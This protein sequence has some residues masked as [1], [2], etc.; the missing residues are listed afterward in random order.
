MTLPSPS[1]NPPRAARRYLR[2]PVPVHFPVSEE[3]PET[4]RHFK[5]RAL[6]A[7]SIEHALGDGALVCSDQF[8]YWDATDP[9]RCLA[10]DVAFRVG[11]KRDVPDT[12]KTWERGAPHVGIEIVSDADSSELR[13]DEKLARYRQAGVLEVVRY[14]WDDAERPIRIWDRVDGDLTERDL[15]D[16]EALRCDPLGWYWCQRRDPELGLVLRL[17]RRPDGSDL[18]LTPLESERAAKDAALAAKDAAL[19]AKDAALAT[20]DAALAAALARVAELEGR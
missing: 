19:A 11:A 12:W 7:A 15:A 3:V 16:P 10:P 1:P 14:D 4:A 6:L 20:Q 18:V 13:F 8:L 2:A 17:A 9:R 5:A